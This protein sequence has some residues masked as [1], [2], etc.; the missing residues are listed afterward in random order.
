MTVFALAPSCAQANR[1]AA[2]QIDRRDATDRPDSYQ[3]DLLAYDPSPFT[4]D[5]AVDP[6]TMLLTLP[7]RDERVDQAVADYMKGFSWYSD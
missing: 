4:S 6:V 3:I 5:G 1:W 2:Q 7:E